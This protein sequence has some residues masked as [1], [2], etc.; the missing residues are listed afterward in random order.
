MRHIAIFLPSLQGGGAERA[1]AVLAN[2]F[3][4]RGLRV[5]LV[6]AKADGPYL[7]EVSE[8]VRIVD[9]GGRRILASLVPLARYLRQERPDAML[10]ALNH[11]NVIAILA[12][13]LARVDLA[14]A[15]S[16]RNSVSRMSSG[17]AGRI[18]W[19]LMRRLY[20][21]ADRVICVSRGI[22]E[23]LFQKLQ[24]ASEQLRTIYNPLDVDGIRRHAT[25][26]PDHRWFGTG[27]PPV[28]VAVGRLTEQKDYP[29]L[30]N[31]FA[32]LRTRRDA[33]LIILG[34][35]EE[36]SALLEL[37]D[38]LGLSGDVEFVGFQDNPY[39]WMAAARLYVMSSAW[40]GLPGALLQAMACGTPIVSTDCPTGPAE[41]LED[42]RWG[43][44]VEV[45]DAVG[46]ARAMEAAL[47][48]DTP[49][50]VQD[51]ADAFRIEYAVEQY[52]EAI[53]PRRGA[54][55]PPRTTRK[56]M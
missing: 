29:T 20:P 51:R 45:G 23:E 10:S 9:L 54:C 32:D 1:M 14:L 16:E 6:L 3:A 56:G 22:E 43:R 31:A 33:K 28:V 55:R 7:S 17:M 38:G 4:A 12:R 30:L 35:G 52:I 42:G 39:R 53:A 24:L 19:F 5:D 2:G 8:S 47:D 46:L 27:Q 25:P 18:T 48:D 37:T 11:A 26:A 44:L 15:V 49:P 40:E 41:I 21:R 34:E 36:R 13:M 50:R